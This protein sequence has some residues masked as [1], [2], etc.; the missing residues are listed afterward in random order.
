MFLHCMLNIAGL[1]SDGIDQYPEASE[2]HPVAGESGMQERLN[3]CVVKRQKNVLEWRFQMLKL[4]Q[5]RLLSRQRFL[6]SLQ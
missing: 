2:Q 3:C 6:Q 4:L 1:V 5:K